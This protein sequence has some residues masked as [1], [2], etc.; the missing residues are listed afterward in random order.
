MARIALVS[1]AHI[2]TRSFLD[3]LAKSGDGRSCVAIWDDV[4][5]RGRRYAQ[6]AGVRFEASLEALLA[7]GDVDGFCVCAEN[8]KHAALLERLIPVGKPIF[9]EKPMV[10]DAAEA[11]LVARLVAQHRTPMVCGWFHQSSREIRTVVR[12]LDAGIV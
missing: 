4:P 11:A 9:V 3:N 6:S 1:A 10:T 8:S 2:H 5:D 12:L 7:A